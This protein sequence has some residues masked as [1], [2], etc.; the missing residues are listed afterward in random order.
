VLSAIRDVCEQPI[1]DL[2]DG[3]GRVQDQIGGAPEKRLDVT[4]PSSSGGM[5]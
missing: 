4:G 1:R 5:G 3:C 2:C